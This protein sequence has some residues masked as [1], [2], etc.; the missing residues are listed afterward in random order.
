MEGMTGSIKLNLGAGELELPGYIPIDRKFGTE[1]FPLE[2]AD[3]SVDEIR[4]SHVLEHF[5][6][7]NIGEVLSNWIRKLRPGG[8]LKI[9]VPNFEV[10]AKQYLAGVPINSQ[11][12]IMGGHTDD[13]D[14]HGVI[15]DKETLVEALADLGMVGMCEWE[16]EIG[17]CA[18]LPISLNIQ[19]YK[20]NAGTPDLSHT[21]AVMASARFGPALHHRCAYEALE[22]LGIHY[23]VSVGCFWA[24]NLC[25]MIEAQIADPDCHYILTA[26]F[27]TMFR[28]EDVLEL[29]R[30][31]AAY[32]EAL[33]IVPVQAKR[34][35]NEALFTIS[36]GKGGLKKTAYEA[37][38]A[39]NLTEINTGHF[40]LTLINADALRALPRPWMNAQP[41]EQGRWNGGH[42]DPDIMFWL[43]WR[44]AG[45]KVYLAN[46]VR[47]GHMQELIT[48][49]GKRFAPIHQTIQD[50]QLNGIPKEAITK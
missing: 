12:Y 24:Q 42:I 13:N 16:S 21:R 6:H 19:C 49:P 2:C 35:S 5:S 14:H 43:K 50:Y 31:A 36:D 44:E 9:A 29:H 39:C 10:I 38:F 48:W 7:R 45:H 20:P 1:V 8:V 17:D 15:F 3:G 28:P 4:A 41:N 30:L 22:R 46:N 40:G 32:K 26:D 37:D 27:D 47:V 34:C 25:E 11:G 23:N 18:S 33:A